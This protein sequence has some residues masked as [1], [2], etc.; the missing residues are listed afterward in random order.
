MLRLM[1]LRHAKTEHDA[2]TGNDRD[3]RLDERGHRDAAAMGA[4]M[5]D[6]GYIPDL[7]LVSPATR[8]QQ[9]WTALVPF[10][11]EV[12]AEFVEELYN[13]ETSDLLRTIRMAAA[14]APRSLL[15][16]AHNPS[17][18]ELG[19]T[20]PARGDKA[21]LQALIGNLPTMGLVVIDFPF[22]D[23]NDVT[24]RSGTLTLFQSPKLIRQPFA[25]D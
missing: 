13:A 2:P 22:D 10:M 17:L 7:A 9:T 24:F 20:L 5:A 1:L 3:R 11:P 12:N 19:L 16:V 21:S 14:S 8:A 23:W 25:S 15:V 18:H 6:Q 4:W